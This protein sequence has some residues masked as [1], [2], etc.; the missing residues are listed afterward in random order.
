MKCDYC[1]EEDARYHVHQIIGTER[2][3]YHICESCAEKLGLGEGADDAL[4]NANQGPPRAGN[5]KECPSCGTTREQFG[6]ESKAGC[7]SCY[8]VFRDTLS[9]ILDESVQNPLH[10]GKL[11]RNLV[12]SKEIQSARRR[13]KDELDR[14]VSEEHYELA[15]SLRDQLDELARLGG[16]HD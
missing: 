5:V 15:A 9:E 8:L 10:R 6:Q 1:R 2:Y 13:L 7:P 4:L 11:P 14:A 3:D 16:E 12:E